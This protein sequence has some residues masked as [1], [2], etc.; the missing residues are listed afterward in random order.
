MNRAKFTGRVKGVVKEDVFQ[1][2][3][4]EYRYKTVMIQLC[5]PESF[6][7]SNVTLAVNDWHEHEIPATGTLVDFTISIYSGQNK[8]NPNIYFHKLNLIEKVA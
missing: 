6:E 7:D 3:G 1:K 5:D 2:E 8:N 4:K